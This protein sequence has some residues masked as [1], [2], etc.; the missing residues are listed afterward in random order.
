MSNSMIYSSG[1]ILIVLL[2]WMVPA[3]ASGGFSNE[4]FEA[5]FSM[6]R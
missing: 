5:W 3:S 1:F 2:I 4:L 6:R